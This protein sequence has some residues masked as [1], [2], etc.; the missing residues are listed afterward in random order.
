ME[1]TMT[2]RNDTPK[3]LAT[4]DEILAQ[5]TYNSSDW[6]CTP[7]LRLL[8][9]LLM[10]LPF[11]T[12]LYLLAWPDGVHAMHASL[13]PPGSLEM[14]RAVVNIYRAVAKGALGFV[15]VDL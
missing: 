2:S 3:A 8:G 15:P 7:E 1:I 10:K 13:E 11:A 4:D 5:V 6:G 9:K 12:P 14:N